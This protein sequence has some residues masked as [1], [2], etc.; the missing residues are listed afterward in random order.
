MHY[1]FTN[2]SYSDDGY[3]VSA[4]QFHVTRVLAPPLLPTYRS[5]GPSS[6]NVGDYLQ[7]G[8]K[9]KAEHLQANLLYDSVILLQNVEEGKPFKL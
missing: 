4:M 8:M 3:V 6:T 1:L 9:T 2:T 7:N 5:P